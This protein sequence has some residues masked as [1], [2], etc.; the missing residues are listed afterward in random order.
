MGLDLFSKPV[1]EMT[2]YEMLQV[3]KKAREVAA[4]LNERYVSSVIDKELIDGLTY[5]DVCLKHKDLLFIAEFV[6]VRLEEFINREIIFAGD[7]ELEELE[8]EGEVE[9]VDDEFEDEIEKRLAE[10][11][12]EEGV[13][14][15]EEKSE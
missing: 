14:E 12:G 11:F 8:E 2:L 13:P 3:I 7:D 6:L 15:E 10:I 1:S 9:E 5:C 4:K